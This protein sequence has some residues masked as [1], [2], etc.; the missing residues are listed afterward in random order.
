MADNNETAEGVAHTVAL[1]EVVPADL[2]V[3][4]EYERD[5]EAVQMAAF[6]PENPDD[7]DAFINHWT[8][9]LAAPGIHAR[10]IV[11]GEEV[12]G[13]VLSYEEAGNPEVTY[14]IGRQH[15]GQGIA[16]QALREF[17]GTVDPRLPMRAR[18]AKDNGASIRVLEKCGFEIIEEVRGFANARGQEI[19]E[20]ELQ[21]GGEHDRS[22]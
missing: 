21:L 20:L 16:T 6:T 11:S 5:P 18:V 7:H 12:L 9:I 10:S 8:R 2:A 19:D 15:W 17:L 4:F 14:W 3:F 13:S 22:D 1:R